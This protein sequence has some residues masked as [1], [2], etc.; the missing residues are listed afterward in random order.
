MK[1]RRLWSKPLLFQ[2]PCII[3]SRTFFVVSGLKM[4]WH[5][6][7]LLIRFWHELAEVFQ[8]QF[9][10]ET[11]QRGRIQLSKAAGE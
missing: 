11:Y 7:S 8:M 1:H 10:K 5:N 6:I 2:I 3:Q 4:D 9:S